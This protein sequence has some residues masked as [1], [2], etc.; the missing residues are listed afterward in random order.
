MKNQFTSIAQHFLAPLLLS[1]V[2]ALYAQATLPPDKVLVRNSRAAVTYRD[3]EAELARIP[4]TERFEI[5]ISRDKTS[6]M[7]ENM[8]TNKT[9]AQEARDNKLDEDPLVRAE[10][11]NQIDKVLA[12]Y[13]GQ[14]VQATLPK[15]DL[16]PR[17]RE[18]Y[19]T[20]PETVTTPPL[21]DVWH[22]LVSL[23]GR[24]AENA[25][26][27][28]EEVRK[29]VLAGESLERLAS[30]YSDDPSQKMNQG[31]LGLNKV[32]GYDPLFAGAIKAM[33]VG[34]V[35]IVES[36][37]GIHVV[38]LL[39]HKPGTRFPFET[40]R[41]YLLKEAETEYIL[42]SWNNYLRKITT[43]PKVFVDVEALESIRPKL[44]PIPAA[45]STA[46][47]TTPAGPAPIAP[48]AATKK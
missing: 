40:A 38:K 7:L 26:A 48:A 30:E 2:T 39:D 45:T 27:R 5:Q 23:K 47:D 16:V 33:K 37:H 1:S 29:K 10:I 18:K 46:P 24:T 15:I 22:A 8:L 41:E 19:L 17:A 35:T 6:L 43:D 9:L 36:S 4:Q 44:P 25:K 14:Q 31:H 34:G 12:K 20:S 11:A 42:A 21:Y 32:D 13:R 3:F 28:A